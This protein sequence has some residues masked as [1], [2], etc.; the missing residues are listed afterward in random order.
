[1]TDP[2]PRTPP[3]YRLLSRRSWPEA[4]FLAD[5]LRTETVGGGLLL[6]GAVVALVWAN[7]PWRSAY[8]ELGGWVPWPGGHALHLD[9][10]LAT[11]AADGLL[12]IFFFVGGL[13]LKREFVAGDLRDPRRAVLPVVAALGGALAQRGQ[14]RD[15]RGGDGAGDARLDVAVEQRVEARVVQ[16]EGDVAVPALP[17]GVDRIVDRVARGD[18]LGEAVVDD[19]VDQPLLAAEVVVERGRGDAGGLADGAGRQLATARRVHHRRGGVQEPVSGVR[20]G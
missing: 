18:V 8:A 3:P 17:D 2:A 6:L 13:E 19:R 16:A 15:G 12:A 7:S 1:M 14:L 10:D 9:L 4:R 11:W 5:V 20:L